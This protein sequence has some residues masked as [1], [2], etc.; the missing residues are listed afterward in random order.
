[1]RDDDTPKRVLLRNPWPSYTRTRGDWALEWLVKQ[2]VDHRAVVLAAC[3]CARLA[4]VHVPDG[5]ERPRKAIE[6][7]EAWARGEATL[8]EVDSTLDAFSAPVRDD[9]SP[10]GWAAYAAQLAAMSAAQLAC[11]EYIREASREAKRVAMYVA[12]ADRA[13]IHGGVGI[14]DCWPGR[15]A[16]LTRC[17]DVVRGRFIDPSEV[18]HG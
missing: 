9:F 17:A 12:N 4:L 18:D 7:A 1:M 11:E 3:E 8:D 2:G 6:A 16:T 10:R 13:R 5:E 15:K 14:H